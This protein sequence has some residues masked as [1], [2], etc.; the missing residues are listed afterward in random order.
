MA[1]SSTLFRSLVASM[2]MSAI[3]LW[4]IDRKIENMTLN[5]TSGEIGKINILLEDQIE[6]PLSFWGSSTTLVHV[7]P[8][9][10]DSITGVN[11]FNFGLDGT[12]FMQYSGFLKSFC[13]RNDSS[14]IAI[15]LNLTDFHPRGQIYHPQ[16]YIHAL[17]DPNVKGALY[18]ID[19]YLTWKMHRIPFYRF[20]LNGSMDYLHLRQNQKS[21]S[22]L[23]SSKGYAGQNKFGT[24]EDFGKFH[25]DSIEIHRPFVDS[26]IAIVSELKASGHR[27]IFFVSPMYTTAFMQI[28]NIRDFHDVLNEI[29]EAGF[30]VLDLTDSP[31][32]KDRNMFYNYLHMNK[33]GA[34][35][36][37]QELSFRMLQYLE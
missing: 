2:V 35:A 18:C 30:P 19:P 13:Q 7:D 5:V 3:V 37:S 22:T 27:P 26:L 6:V 23:I 34:E 21:D 20:V 24:N 4:G 12:F 28:K 9:I 10:V 11:A 36:F 33:Y 15:G 17:D 16:Y 8:S 31:I 29:Q 1:P 32:S 14:V 25:Y